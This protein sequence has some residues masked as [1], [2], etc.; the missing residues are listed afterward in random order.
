MVQVEH[1]K[2]SPDCQRKISDDSSVGSHKS[3][4][5]EKSPYIR[6]ALKEQRGSA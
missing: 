6:K 3:V 4:W 2:F 1:V 5:F